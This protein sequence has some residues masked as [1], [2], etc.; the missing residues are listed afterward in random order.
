MT[1]MAWDISHDTLVS[2]VESSLSST[3]E[4]FSGERKI[5]LVEVVEFLGDDSVVFC[6]CLAF[7]DS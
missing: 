6:T 1:F 2:L 7:A 5:V 3:V 4:A